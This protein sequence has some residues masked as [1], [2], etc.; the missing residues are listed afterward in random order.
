MLLLQNAFTTKLLRVLLL[1][2]KLAQSLVLIL[3]YLVVIQI[4]SAGLRNQ[5]KFE[6]L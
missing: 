3:I 1:R 2:I 4:Y 5:C 6:L